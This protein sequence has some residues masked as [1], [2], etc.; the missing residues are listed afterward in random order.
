MKSGNRKSPS[1]VLKVLLRNRLA[2]LGMVII[3]LLS[4][5]AVFAPLIAPYDYARQRLERGYEIPSKDFWLGTD[6]YGRDVFSRIVYGARVS[7][8]VGFVTVG[9]GL[10]LG[11]LIGVTAGYYGGMAGNILMRLMDILL[12]MPSILLAIAIAASLG[13][14]LFNLMIAVG[15]SNIPRYARIARGSVLSVRGMEYIEAARAAGSGDLRILTRHVIPNCT[16][17]LIVQATLG[18]ASAILNAA[19]LSFIG[20]GIQP[21][22]PEWGAMLSE[23]RQLIRELPHLTLFPGLAIMFTILGFNFLGDGLRDALDPRMRR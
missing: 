14:G 12:A 1:R 4:L 21:P 23:G 15:I 13:A 6:E 16:A 20:L 9:I 8:A 17:P 11:V 7:L 18:V 5:G 22:F 10:I 19:A 2:V 3:V